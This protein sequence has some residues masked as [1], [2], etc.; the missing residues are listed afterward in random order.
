M[1][2]LTCLTLS[3]F[4]GDYPYVKTNG[5]LWFD[6]YTAAVIANRL[7]EWQLLTNENTVLRKIVDLSSNQIVYTTN[8]VRITTDCVSKKAHVSGCVNT[9][10]ISLVVGVL[11][12]I[13][14]SVR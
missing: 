4:P 3:T 1:L 11:V 10:I 14:V 8:M 13:F 7:Q 9:G 5:G 2:L 6:P 12:G